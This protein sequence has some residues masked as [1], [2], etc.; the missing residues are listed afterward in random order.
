LHDQERQENLTTGKL[1]KTIF[2]SKNLPVA[3]VN[4]L[5]C[6]KWRNNNMRILLKLELLDMNAMRSS[7]GLD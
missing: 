1:E 5:P 3:R 7:L 2:L 6:C 4:C